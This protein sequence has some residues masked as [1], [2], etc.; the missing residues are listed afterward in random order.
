MTIDV[1]TVACRSGGELAEFAAT[2]AT[3]PKDVGTV[4]LV[5][6]RPAVGE[7]QV[8]EVGRLDTA[9]GLLGD[10]WSTRSSSRSADGGPHPRMQLNVM[11]WPVAAFLAVDPSRAPLAGDQLYVDLDLSHDNLPVGTRLRFGDP[12][13]P[14]SVIEVTEVP[15]NG[16]AK[17]V[18]RFGAEAMRFVNGAFGRPLRLRG[19][20]AVVVQSGEVRTGDLVSVVRPD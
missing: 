19:L 17:F 12:Q 20:N 14:S 13:E 16:C 2:L 3:L 5:V 10:T 1:P 7:R 9:G 15:H 8:L 4:R 11:S 6:I 18:S